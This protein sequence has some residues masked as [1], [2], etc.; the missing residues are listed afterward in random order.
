MTKRSG[1]TDR[2]YGLNN[3]VDGK[4]HHQP[5]ELFRG[6]V[7]KVSGSTRPGEPAGFHTL[8]KQKE[9]VPFPEKTFDPGR[10]VPAEKK[11]RVGDKEAHLVSLFDHGGKGIDPVTH[12]GVTADDVD[13]GK[14]VWVSIL[15]HG[16]PP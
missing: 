10:G 5:A 14:G 12:V 15:K 1:G 3:R 16:A 13:A 4:S 7:P 11:Q 2:I 6:N 8:V 9:S